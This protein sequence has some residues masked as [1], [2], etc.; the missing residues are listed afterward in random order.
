M[1]YHAAQER[2]D[3]RGFLDELQPSAKG[4]DKA[5]D[6]TQRVREVCRTCACVW[7]MCDVM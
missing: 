5:L 1:T 2:V 6:T 7:A 3:Y 4:V